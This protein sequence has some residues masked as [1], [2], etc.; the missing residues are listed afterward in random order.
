MGGTV[1]GPALQAH[2]VHGGIH[3]HQAA[4][5]ET[6]LPR[7]S[8]LPA[9]HVL[10]DRDDALALLDDIRSDSAATGAPKVAV[11][12]G[13]AGIGKTAVALRWSHRE[14]ASFPDGQLF[15]DLRGAAIEKP[16]QPTEVLGRFIRAF[17][18]SPERIPAGLAERSALYQSLVSGRRLVVVLDNAVSAAQVA[19]LLPASADSVTIVTS[20]WR[21]A[22]LLMRGARAVRLEQLGAQAALELLERT[23]GG[24]RVRA[25]QESAERLVELCARLPLALCVAAARL[26]TR[27]R[28]PLSEMVRAL[29]HERRRLAELSIGDE[30]ET[31]VQAA[32]TLSYDG[33]SSE[34]AGR[35]YRRLGLFPGATF[36]SWSAAATVAMPRVHVRELLETLTDANLLDDAPGGH[37]RFHDLTR[38]HAREMAERDEPDAVERTV[39]RAVDWF[40]FTAASVNRVVMPYRKVD[41]DAVVNEPADLLTFDDRAEALN[42]LD[43]EFP[44]FR[45]AIR[46]AI[47]R[48]LFPA[49]WQL[50]DALWPLFL[51]R[52]HHDERL[53]VDLM[54]L[55]AAR[56][57]ANSVAEAK[58]LDRIGLAHRAL[59]ELDEAASD[60]RAAL[61]IW[62][63]EGN[64][65]KVSSS[66]HKLGLIELDRGHVEEA[67][68]LFRM[69]L[70]EYRSVNEPREVA[71]LLRDLSEALIESGETVEAV[72]HL[73]EAEGLLI[74]VDDP[75]NRA[76]ARILLGNARGG[77]PGTALVNQGLEE[78]KK[79]GSATGQA[80]ALQALGDLALREH[81]E[82]DARALYEA[83]QHVLSRSGG[84]SRQL[85]KR[86]SRLS[87]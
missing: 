21:L 41:F 54:G 4:S 38:L 47:D 87:R 72:D 2:D 28:W 16:V 66:T 51:Y 60:F 62:R 65:R 19:P 10:V 30:D 34:D 32:L 33:I 69:W 77:E 56:A 50:V 14:R 67:I 86:L 64:P 83:A 52:G 73:T 76:R 53:E 3:L 23:I 48:E 78:M 79:I 61:E 43:D 70:N 15:A 1:F 24:D 20:R 81:R 45:A 63:R 71:L 37:Y 82:Q 58:M 22:G 40:L 46:V 36:D 26:A 80:Q 44:N 57:C 74:D 5:P 8:Q 11:V 55:E 6:P 17:G 12:S 29:T 31:K 7:P 25:E 59:D 75:Y 39:H 13:P 9:G 84:R 35:V 49:A 68:A 18:V 27:P 42:W 85:Q